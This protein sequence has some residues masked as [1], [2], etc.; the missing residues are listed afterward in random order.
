MLELCIF[1]EGARYPEEICAMG[2]RGKIEAPVP[3]PQRF[4]PEHLGPGPVPQVVVSPRVPR[5][6]RVIEV[7]VD[8]ALLAAGDHN[9]STF[10]Q[11]Q[12][13]HAVVR[14]EGSPEVTLADGMA[15][16][17]IGLAVQESARSGRAVML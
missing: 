17:R 7:P 11:H 5:R 14:G 2:P 12:A 4:W 10:Y 1:A 6:P 16:V 13:F 3:G 9:G 15:A 8:P